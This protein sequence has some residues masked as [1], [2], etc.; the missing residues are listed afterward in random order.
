MEFVL[1]K[2]WF[3]FIVKKILKGKYQNSLSHKKDENKTLKLFPQP[4]IDDTHK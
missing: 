3:D 1:G 2:S 4:I